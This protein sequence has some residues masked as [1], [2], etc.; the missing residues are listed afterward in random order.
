MT[1][2]VP[3]Q[4]KTMVMVIGTGGRSTGWLTPE[5]MQAAEDVGRLLAERGVVVM[6]GGGSGIMEAA[7]KGAA[8]AGGITVG[9]VPGMDKTVVNP[10][11]QIPITTGIGTMRNWLELRACDAVIMVSGGIGT[12]NELT[13]AMDERIIPAVVLEGT[14]GWSDRI[15]E[16]A[17]DGK[18]MDARRT[19]PVHFADSPE[20]AVEL[21]LELAAERRKKEEEQAATAKREAIR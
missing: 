3:S 10:Y 12:L 5:A 14:G 18:Y 16:I 9:I 21:T 20:K 4:R 6:T 7:L 2:A 19:V 17:Y 15:R 11:C 1:Q 13:I 8:E